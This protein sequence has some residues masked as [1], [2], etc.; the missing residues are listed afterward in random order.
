MTDIRDLSETE[1]ALFWVE[2]HV[3]FAY[4]IED[5]FKILI[6]LLFGTSTN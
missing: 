4:S 5:S 2:A 1:S 6:V 3:D